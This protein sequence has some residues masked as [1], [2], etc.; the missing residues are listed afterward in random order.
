MLLYINRDHKNRDGQTRTTTLT[1]TQL[2]NSHDIYIYPSNRHMP[3]KWRMYSG[4]TWSHNWGGGGGGIKQNKI[5]QNPSLSWGWV[6]GGG[7]RPVYTH[8]FCWNRPVNSKL[9]IT[10]NEVQCSQRTK[11]CY[12]VSS[13]MHTIVSLLSLESIQQLRNQNNSKLSKAFLWHVDTEN[14]LTVPNFWLLN[15]KNKLNVPNF[16]LLNTENK[17][18]VSNFRL[19]NTQNKLIV[20][21]SGF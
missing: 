3:H 9:D 17:L 12:S 2:L 16:R 8:F 4:W 18:I 5:H 20:P 13:P 11:L 7:S 1:F 10:V 14:K 21:I 15:T 19:L 6:G